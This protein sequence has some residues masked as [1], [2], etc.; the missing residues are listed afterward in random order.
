MVFALKK[1]LPL[2]LAAALRAFPP[3]AG[4]GSPGSAD[5]LAGSPPFLRTSAPGV[6]QE[7]EDAAAAGAATAPLVDAAVRAPAPGAVR[8]LYHTR[9]R[10]MGAPGTAHSPR[11]DPT[12]C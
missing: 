10:G 1:N 7:A 2:V 3:A 9:V 11:R 12:I 8:C 6:L 5:V 4:G